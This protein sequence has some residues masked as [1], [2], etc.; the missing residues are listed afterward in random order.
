LRKVRKTSAF[1]ALQKIKLPVLSRRIGI[2]F[3]ES[4]NKHKNNNSL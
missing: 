2:R 1:E 3:L 4:S